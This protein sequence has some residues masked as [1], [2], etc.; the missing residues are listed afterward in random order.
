L[1]DSH[2]PE[3]QR[4]ELDYSQLYTA[5]QGWM[6]AFIVRSLEGVVQHNII[7]TGKL[8]QSLTTEDFLRAANAMRTEIE[9]HQVS[10]DRPVKPEL[11]AALRALIADEVLSKVYTNDDGEIV[12]DA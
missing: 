4:T 5:F 6:P 12:I 9:A 3:S 10:T 2:I 1:I 8:G 7:R 11:E